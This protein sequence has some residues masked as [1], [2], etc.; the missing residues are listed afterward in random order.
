MTAKQGLSMS[1]VS[2]CL[3]I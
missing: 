2:L 1:F 3:G